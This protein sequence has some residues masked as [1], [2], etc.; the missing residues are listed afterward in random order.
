MCVITGVI[1]WKLLLAGGMKN[2]PELDL[3]LLLEAAVPTAQNIVMLVLVHSQTPEHGQALAYIIL[4]QYALAIP[5]LIMSVAIFL[6]M[7]R[8]VHSA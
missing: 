5:I 4:W 6:T 3:V 8:Q 1:W 7:V 2:P